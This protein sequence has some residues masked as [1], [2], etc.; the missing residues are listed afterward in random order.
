MAGKDVVLADDNFK[1]FR[2]IGIVATYPNIVSY[3]HP[4]LVND[5]GSLLDFKNLLQIFERKRF[6]NG[7]LFGDN[8]MLM[9]QTKPWHMW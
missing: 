2:T 6:L 7:Y 5:K 3:V 1:D 4:S 9:A 8:F